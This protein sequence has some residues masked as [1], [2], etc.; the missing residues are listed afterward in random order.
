M[1][2]ESLPAGWAPFDYTPRTRLVFGVNA[3]EKSEREKSHSD[4]E[5]KNPIVSNLNRWY[6]PS[7]Y[8]SS[9]F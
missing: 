5:S 1:Q 4:K 3:V 2:T 6:L 8:S 9:Y 7:Y